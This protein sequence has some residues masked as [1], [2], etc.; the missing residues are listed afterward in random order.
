MNCDLP[1]KISDDVFQVY[2]IC[3][4]EK[5]WWKSISVSDPTGHMQ[6]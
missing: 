3:E 6:A 5:R 1:L 2:W 4:P